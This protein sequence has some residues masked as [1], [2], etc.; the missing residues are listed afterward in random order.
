MN[1]GIIGVGKLGLAYALVFEES[2]FSVFASSYKQEYVDKLCAKDVYTVEPG[3][4][5]LF[6]SSTRIEYTTDNN[7]VIQNCEYIYVMVATPSNPDGSYNV[8]AVESVVEDFVNYPD[9]ISNK[10]LII[11]STVNPGDCARLQEKLR[12]RGVILL[13]SPTFVAQGSVLDRIYN[14]VGVLWGTEDPE[15][16]EECISI[17]DKFHKITADTTVVKHTTAEILKIAFNCWSTMRMSFFNSIG[18]LAIK[19][20]VSE[21]MDKINYSINE[22]NKQWTG[23]GYGFGGPCLPRDN[24]SMVHYA[25][26]IGSDY[27][28]GDV[29]DKFNIDHSKFLAQWITEQNTDNLPFYFDYLTYKPGVNLPDEA[30][31]FAVCKHLLEAGHTVY[32][33]PSEFL[34]R[35]FVEAL[36]QYNTVHYE[37]N[38]S[39]QEKNI[40][41]YTVNI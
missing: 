24:R 39:L 25:R 36:A 40:D 37:S 5:E 28:L 32:V 31:Q 38:T 6:E 27:V 11:G 1:I 21:D 2:G 30:S 14:P 23:F 9:D 20:G 7:W 18:Q 13:Y 34:P 4:Q 29:V 16:A 17:W 3:V 19:S 12:S 22:Y 8:D 26:S 10:R 33:K 35:E 41:F 15:I